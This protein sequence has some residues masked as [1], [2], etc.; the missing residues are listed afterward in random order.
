M[1]SQKG[2]IRKRV[3]TKKAPGISSGQHTRLEWLDTAQI[4]RKG[5]TPARGHSGKPTAHQDS[6]RVRGRA[7][8]PSV[9]GLARS[10]FQAKG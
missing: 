3:H 2:S 5:P 9:A 6:Q 8:G 4:S 1:E 7:R 10:A